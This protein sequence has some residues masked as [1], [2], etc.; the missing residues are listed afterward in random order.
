MGVGQPD[1]Q[2]SQRE[3]LFTLLPQEEVGDAGLEPATFWV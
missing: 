2:H 1:V 3:I